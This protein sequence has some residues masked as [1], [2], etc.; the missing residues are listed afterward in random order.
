MFSS[1]TEIE[2]G[3]EVITLPIAPSSCSLQYLVGFSRANVF[4]SDILG[5]VSEKEPLGSLAFPRLLSM[6]MAWCG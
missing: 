5:C 6:E 4:V 2:I 1:T 3:T